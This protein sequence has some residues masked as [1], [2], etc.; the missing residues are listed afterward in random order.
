MVRKGVSVCLFPEG[1]RSF[2]GRTDKLHP[3]TG[4]LIKLCNS[5]VVTYRLEGGYLSSPRWGHGLRRGRIRGEVVNVY[6]A[7]EI[8][9]MSAE[10]L[11]ER[12]NADI[13]ENAFERQK[14]TALQIYR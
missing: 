8:K 9:N 11:V 7:D 3:T 2:D 1:T 13:Y 14:K 5:T 6:S 12:V 4:R 10:E